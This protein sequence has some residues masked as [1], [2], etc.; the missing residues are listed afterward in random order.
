M[1]KKRLTFT[2]IELLVVIAIIAILASM[3][4]PALGKAK[5]TARTSTCSNNLK[6]FAH[7]IFRYAE[8][9]KGLFP[10]A[11]SYSSWIPALQNGGYYD[12]SFARGTLELTN[13]GDNSLDNRYCPAGPNKYTTPGVFY[14]VY[15]YV[16]RWEADTNLK[17][18]RDSSNNYCNNFNAGMNKA[19]RSM[20]MSDSIAYDTARSKWYQNQHVYSSS[21]PYNDS[22]PV[23]GMWHNKAA[24]GVFAD[25]HVERYSPL[26]CK[27][28]NI[29]GA[30]TKEG[31]L[32][33]KK[34]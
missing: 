18:I 10:I 7:M 4:L 25:G 33:Y 12:V 11:L 26:D 14:S 28:L 17:T 19:S 6:T 1:S 20:I 34:Q 30:K 23:S 29:L 24:N 3:L 8:D 27:R 13:K 15:G 21:W 5:D 9:H 32:L 16:Y 2:L 31:G 22:Y